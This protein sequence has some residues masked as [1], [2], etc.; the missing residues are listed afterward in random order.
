L[1]RYTKYGLGSALQRALCE[2]TITKYRTDWSGCYLLVYDK[3]EVFL[4]NSIKILCMISDPGFIQSGKEIAFMAR[5][6]QFT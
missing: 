2:L 5:Y 1:L 6:E 3:F 4:A